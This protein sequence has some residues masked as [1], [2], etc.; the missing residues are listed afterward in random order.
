MRGTHVTQG[1]MKEP[2]MDAWDRSMLAI[3]GNEYEVQEALT[4][5]RRLIESGAVRPT[6]RVILEGAIEALRGDQA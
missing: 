6:T 2:P 5:L 3:S 1:G 4:V